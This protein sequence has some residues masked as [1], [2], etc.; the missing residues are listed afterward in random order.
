[1]FIL[2]TLCEAV[3]LIKQGPVTHIGNVDQ[4]NIFKWFCVR[5]AKDNEGCPYKLLHHTWRMEG[6]AWALERL[7][8]LWNASVITNVLTKM[9]TAQDTL[10]LSLGGANHP[11][12][13]SVS[14]VVTGRSASQRINP[15]VNYA[16]LLKIS[17]LPTWSNSNS[18][19]GLAGMR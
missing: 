15:F 16:L 1:M 4:P 8:T 12:L 10:D 19:C 5:R 18:F 6:N 7:L 11:Q 13:L 9:Q 3:V 2:P 14:V 17:W